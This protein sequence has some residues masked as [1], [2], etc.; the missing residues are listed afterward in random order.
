[1]RALIVGSFNPVTNAH[2]AM[3]IAAQEWIGPHNTVVYVLAS[4][5][6]ISDSKGYKEG[7]TLRWDIRVKLLAEAVS[8]YGFVPSPVECDG[9]LDGK[10]YHTMEYYGFDDTVLCIGMDNVTKIRKWYK[11]R[12]L[13]E[14][15]RLLVFERKGCA[16]SE[17]GKE[18]LELSKGYQILEL[19][20]DV[21]C[22]SSTQIR[23]C[24]KNGDMGK[25]KG[26]V[27]EPVYQYLKER[28]H[29]YV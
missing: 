11:G 1:M 22:V 21:S 2:I 8:R 13:L 27:P 28:K 9:T 18:L 26:L 6:Y 25:V 14:Q 5:K 16:L 29:V 7:G 23:N 12:E 3:G 10:T 19:P 17:Q 20:D 4:D 24:Y 15:A